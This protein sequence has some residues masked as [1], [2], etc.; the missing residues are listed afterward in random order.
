MKKHWL[1]IL[2]STLLIAFLA[3]AQVMAAGVGGNPPK[4]PTHTPQATKTGPQKKGPAALHA[5]HQY[6]TG[7]IQVVSATSLVLVLREG[8]TQSFV[9]DS[10]TIVKV[11]TLG[12]SAS[13]SDLHAGQKVGVHTVD[14]NGSL[15]A[16]VIQVIPGKP[17]FMQRV[18]V[19]TAYTAGLSITI[20]AEDG[21]AYTFAI[22][23]A[24]RMLPSG[25]DRLLQVGSRVTIIMPRDVTGGI[26]TAAGIVVHPQE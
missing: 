11:P 1:I 3:T 24:T 7:S 5:R 19:V 22:T 8:S 10:N 23:S 12:Q 15:I 16:R 13:V 26:P 9:L 6:Y 2:F 25:P 14:N 4:K 20:T 18:G 17:V 21:N